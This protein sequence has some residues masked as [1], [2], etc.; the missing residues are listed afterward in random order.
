MGASKS[1]FGLLFLFFSNP[2]SQRYSP[3]FSSRIVLVSGSI[4]RSMAYL[5]LIIQLKIYIKILFF[6][7]ISFFFPQHYLHRCISWGGPFNF[8]N[9][10]ILNFFQM[11]FLCILICSMPHLVRHIGRYLILNQTCI[12]RI[13]SLS[14]EVLYSL[15]IS[16]FNLLIFYWK[17]YT[18]VQERHNFAT[19][20]LF[21]IILF[22]AFI[23]ILFLFSSVFMFNLLISLCFCHI[24]WV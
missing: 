2:K 13:V 11:L 3:M 18:H 5:E 16:E 22:S 8:Y 23:F 14:H 19:V 4:F 9:E 10:W 24:P 6:K 17:F 1:I 20:F 21:S 12:L 7:W 15:Y